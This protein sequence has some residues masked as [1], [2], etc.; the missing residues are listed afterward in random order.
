MPAHQ[1]TTLRLLLR[2]ENGING[3]AADGAL[4]LQG[5]FAILHRDALGVL[6]LSLRFALHTIVR[7]GH[8]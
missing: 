7:I 3:R 2:A 6:H 1:E 8:D 4:A 5:L